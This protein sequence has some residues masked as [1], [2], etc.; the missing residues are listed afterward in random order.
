M[1]YVESGDLKG[2][3]GKETLEDAFVDVFDAIVAREGRPPHLGVLAVGSTKGF[4]FE[5]DSDASF[6]LPEWPL[7]NAGR[8]KKPV[9][10]VSPVEEL[11]EILNEVKREEVPQLVR[12]SPDAVL[13]AEYIDAPNSREDFWDDVIDG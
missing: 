5:K 9:E 4:D 13:D 7:R 11:M 12:V 10:A 3:S 2:V 6:F 1:W 8:I